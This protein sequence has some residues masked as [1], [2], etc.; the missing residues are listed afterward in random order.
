[1]IEIAADTPNKK[2]RMQMMALQAPQLQPTAPQ[3]GPLGLATD[4][5][6]DRAMN[7]A[8]GEAEKAI[9]NPALE[10]GKEMAIAKATEMGLMGA[11]GAGTM[12]TLGTAMP[13]IGAGLLAGKAVGLFE[14]GGRVNTTMSGMPRDKSNYGLREFLD[15]YGPM[16]NLYRLIYGHDENKPKM[17]EGMMKAGKSFKGFPVQDRY[18]VYKESGGLVG[19]LAIRKIKYKQDGGKVEVEAIMG[20]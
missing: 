2:E 14:E 13:Y 8:A 15:D 6:K 10:K 20:E 1:M 5:A 7:Y 18:S 17:P 4:F 12:A 16:S 19:P 11:S 3:Q 9:V